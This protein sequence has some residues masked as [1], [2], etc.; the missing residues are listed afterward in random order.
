MDEW[1]E[2]KRRRDAELSWNVHY[3]LE[4][5]VEQNAVYRVKQWMNELES[6]EKQQIEKTN[7]FL[8]TDVP[9][10][11]KK[12]WERILEERGIQGLA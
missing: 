12:A 3:S 10:F 5:P 1:E 6:K 8:F 9:E 2:L 7:A 4:K 11:D